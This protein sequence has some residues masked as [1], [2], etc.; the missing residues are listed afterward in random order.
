MSESLQDVQ[1]AI[2][3]SSSPAAE[4]GQLS[5]ARQREVFFGLPE[6]VRESLVA[7]MDEGALRRFVRGLD[8]DEGADVLGFFI[9]LGLARSVL[10][11]P[12]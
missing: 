4:F 11:A 12:A 1:Q 3:A 9:F 7:D 2:A 8:P 5:R 6:T 10:T